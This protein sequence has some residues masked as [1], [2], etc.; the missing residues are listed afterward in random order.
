MSMSI[1]DIITHELFEKC[2]LEEVVINN[3]TSHDW[4]VAH[5]SGNQA[6]PI[7]AHVCVCVFFFFFF[8]YFFAPIYIESISSIIL[9]G[10][11]P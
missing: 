8:F 1:L 4:L 9:G 11:C 10:L 3:R 5:P 2:A 7:I 6:L